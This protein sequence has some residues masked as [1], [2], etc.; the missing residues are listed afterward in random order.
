MIA[1]HFGVSRKLYG[2]WHWILLQYMFPCAILAAMFHCQKVDEHSN[3]SIESIVAPMMGHIPTIFLYN[4]GFWNDFVWESPGAHRSR[5]SQVWLLLSPQSLKTHCC[6]GF[7][8]TIIIAVSSYY[9]YCY[10][11]SISLLI[12]DYCHAMYYD[13][14]NIGFCLNHNYI[15]HFSSNPSSP[16][17]KTCFALFCLKIRKPIPDIPYGMLVNNIHRV[18]PPLFRRWFLRS[19]QSQAFP[20]QGLAQSHP[21]FPKEMSSVESS[22]PVTG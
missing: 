18:I 21:K 4:W 22:H 16:G 11:I 10:C 8:M 9:G 20:D 19:C 12:V 1:S 5:S 2:P 3:I 17:K 14:S 7:F 15:Q 6:F 13:C